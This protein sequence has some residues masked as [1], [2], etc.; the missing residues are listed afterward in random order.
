MLNR[1]ILIGRLTD[2]PDLSYTTSGIALGTFTLA[3]ERNF[4][5]QKGE[6]ETDFIPIKVWRKLAEHCSSYLGKGRLVCVEGQIQTGSYKKDGKT[7]KSFEVVADNV[8]FLDWPKDKTQGQI[9]E[10]LD[11]E[12]PF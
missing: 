9:Q 6:K 7:R 8:R 2:I 11:S 1:V 12:V 3:V 4:K 10:D 5:N